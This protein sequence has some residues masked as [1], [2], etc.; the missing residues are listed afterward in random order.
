MKD[1]WIDQ[2]SK[3]LARQ[4]DQEIVDNIMAEKLIR[5]G[6]TR[7][8]VSMER[9]KITNTIVEIAAWVHTTATADYKLVQNYWYFEHPADATAFA[10][11][12]A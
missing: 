1:D 11:R 9:Y 8:N 3:H 7:A 2:A 4:I 12:W 6:W 5:D 10:L